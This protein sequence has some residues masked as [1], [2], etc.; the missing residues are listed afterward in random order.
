MAD[1]SSRSGFPRRST[2]RHVLTSVSAIRSAVRPT[3]MPSSAEH[4]L[5]LCEPVSVRPAHVLVRAARLL[6]SPE[7]TAFPPARRSVS[8]EPT[9]AR[10][11]QPSV[12]PVPTSFPR[13]QS[14]S[15]AEQ[16]AARAI[17]ALVS[18]VQALVSPIQALVR[19][20]QIDALARSNVLKPD[21]SGRT[22]MAESNC[23]IEERVGW[24]VAA[25]DSRGKHL[26]VGSYMST[27]TSRR[28]GL[29]CSSGLRDSKRVARRRDQRRR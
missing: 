20:A 4:P 14:A 11:E 8:A 18:P 13:E 15:R 28:N 19:A 29:F 3:Q 9:E 22:R 27:R 6:S 26:G 10:A 16:S 7:P 24:Q 2:L 25:M 5:P 1:P 23:E 21:E 12:H 17:Q